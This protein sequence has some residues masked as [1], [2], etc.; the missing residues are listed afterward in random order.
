VNSTHRSARPAALA[1]LAIVFCACE[2][3]TSPAPAV[4]DPA[5]AAQALRQFDENK[6]GM[7]IHWGLYAIPAGE[8]KGQYV[9]GIGE[10]IM[11]RAKIP[12]HEYEQLAAQFNP[13]KFSGAEWAQLA[14]DAGMRYLVITSKHHDGFAMYGSK[15]SKYNI[16]DATPYGRDPMKEL[17]AACA[18]RGLGF[19]FYYSQDQ[20]WHERN[21]RGNTWDFPAERRPQ[22]YLEEKVIPQVNEI[23]SGYGKLSLIWFDTPGMLSEEQVKNLRR[24]VKTAQPACLLNSRIGHGQGDYFQTGDNAIPR[25]IPRR[26]VKFPPP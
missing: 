11:F 21:G 12:V 13:V 23:L 8:W 3:T 2:R 14:A 6:F 10:W 7:F 19:G 4:E 17:S 25:S 5:P 26:S 1:A 18:E 15:A 16:V 20:D 24:T 9:R 22:Q